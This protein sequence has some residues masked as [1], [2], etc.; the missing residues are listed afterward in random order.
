MSVLCIKFVSLLVLN[1]SV[2]GIKFVS[3]FFW[4]LAYLCEITSEKSRKVSLKDEYIY[5]RARFDMTTNTIHVVISR[6]LF[7]LIFNFFI[8]FLFKKF[9][10][11]KKKKA[12]FTPSFFLHSTF[13][14]ENQNAD[15][16]Q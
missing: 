5:T 13:S 4:I 3:T 10:S 12:G 9:F 11:K 2:I 7:F 14:D 15:V 1:L 16:P 8:I 6:A